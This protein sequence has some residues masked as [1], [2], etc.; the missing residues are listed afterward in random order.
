MDRVAWF[1]VAQVH[2]NAPWLTEAKVVHMGLQAFL[3]IG[4]VCT[5]AY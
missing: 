3:C 5:V 4:V 2:V 1:H